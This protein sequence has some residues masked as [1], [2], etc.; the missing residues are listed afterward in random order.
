MGKLRIEFLKD[1]LMKEAIS[2]E[3]DFI[4]FFL[5]ITGK[6]ITFLVGIIIKHSCRLQ[7]KI[8]EYPLVFEKIK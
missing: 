4:L 1:L 5:Q 6:L 8:V 3:Q 2:K 7:R